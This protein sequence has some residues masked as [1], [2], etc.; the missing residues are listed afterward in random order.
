MYYDINNNDI[1]NIVSRKIK[2]CYSYLTGALIITFLVSFFAYTNE[3]F[4]A[5]ANNLL[6]IA[7][8]IQ[9]AVPF[10]MAMFI[11][12]AKPGT[13][14]I[15]L[16]VYSASTGILLSYIAQIYTIQSVLSV[17]MSTICLFAVLSIYGFITRSNLMSY[18]GFLFVGL[19][20][21]IIMSVINIFLRSS[22]L[23]LMLA[24]LGVIVFV[25][26]VAYDTQLIKNKIVILARQGQLDLL[27]RVEIVGAFSLYLDF[28]NL[29][30]YLIRLFGRRKN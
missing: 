16:L 30:I 18:S 17:L 11:Y 3:A 12:K 14:L 4:N 8:I 20:S 9:F 13:L 2:G 22:S 25:I 28:I 6:P 24:I 26:Y 19:V 29:F 21:I 15:G 10:M 27:D 23:D 7:L 5:V 1:E